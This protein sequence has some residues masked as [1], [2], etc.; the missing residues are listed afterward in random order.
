MIFYESQIY[1][2][3]DAENA[4]QHRAR[5]IKGKYFE[6]MRQLFIGPHT[7]RLNIVLSFN[8]EEFFGQWYHKL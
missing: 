1:T 8:F 5:N 4:E 3:N 7:V 2:S 6:G